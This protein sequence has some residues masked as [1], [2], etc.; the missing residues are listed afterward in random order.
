MVVILNGYEQASNR[1][2]V[3]QLE[4]GTGGATD[5]WF[6]AHS[7]VD[8]AGASTAVAALAAYGW[9]ATSVLY[10]NTLTADFI[11]SLDDTPPVYG[12]NASGDILLSPI[13]FGSYAHALGASKT[14]GFVP[15]KLCAEWYGA[16]TTASANEAA[17]Y[18]GWKNSGLLMA[19]YSNGT[20]FLLSN[21]GGTTDTGA[22]I[23]TSY[24]T[25]KL[26]TDATNTEWFI[27][28]TS[29]GTVATSADQWPGGFGFTTS[30]TNRPQI[31]WA[32]VW[33]E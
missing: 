5:F 17:T 13:I 22:A 2:H 15:T 14:L 4:W 25:W 18:M 6:Q 33:Y 19:V 28:G 32:H 29:Q 9:V 21:Q 26:V 7:A 12:A 8:S 3:N 16:F 10:T 11:S 23:D 24:H 30:T 1:K 20:N 27:D 31:S